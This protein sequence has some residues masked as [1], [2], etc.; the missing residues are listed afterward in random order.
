M[1]MDVNGWLG[2]QMP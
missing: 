1:S 2:Y